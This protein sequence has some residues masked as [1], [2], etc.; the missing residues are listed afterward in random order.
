MGWFRVMYP[1]DIFIIVRES[2]Q[3]WAPTKLFFGFLINPNIIEK[4]TLIDKVEN[5]VAIFR[6]PPINIFVKYRIAVSIGKIYATMT[7]LFTIEVFHFRFHPNPF[8]TAFSTR[9]SICIDPEDF[10]IYTGT[11][12]GNLSSRA[13]VK[14]SSN[15]LQS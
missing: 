12:S 1:T 4:R 6:F 14:R 13:R 5:I 11:S 10:C 15:S 2:F 8:F 9:T 7:A 3:P